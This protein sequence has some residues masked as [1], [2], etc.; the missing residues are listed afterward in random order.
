MSPVAVTTTA[1]ASSRQTTKT[2]ASRGRRSRGTRRAVQRLMVVAS[3][4]PHEGL[5]GG[6]AFGALGAFGVADLT[7]SLVRLVPAICI[8][9]PSPR[10][11]ASP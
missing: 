2:S 11:Q 10:G 1:A 4:R 5:R 9:I 6:G 8:A 3:T 7:T